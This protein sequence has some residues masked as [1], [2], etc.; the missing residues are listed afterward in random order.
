MLVNEKNAQQKKRW[1]IGLMNKRENPKELHRFGAVFCFYV[2]KCRQEE[3][4]APPLPPDI[5]IS[6]SV[7]QDFQ[8]LHR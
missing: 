1:C 5:S 2:V 4:Q 6:N 7:G 8:T 3:E